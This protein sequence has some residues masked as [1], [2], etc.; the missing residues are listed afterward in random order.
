MRETGAELAGEMSGYFFFKERWYGFE[1]ALSC[2]ARLLE[3]LAQREDNPSQ[4]FAALPHAC[5]TAQMEQSVEGDA[6][7]CVQSFIEEVQRSVEGGVFDGARLFAF[8]GLRAD[9]T[10]GWGLVRVSDTASALVLRFE[11]CTR[12]LDWSGFRVRSARICR[13][14]YPVRYWC[15]KSFNVYG[16]ASGEAF[17]SLLFN[18][19]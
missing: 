3:I 7:A 19:R 11:G 1:D 8:D 12:R 18:A 9:F 10:D 16:S 6:Q 17:A 14:Y 15:S 5:F 2:G 4:V 13:H